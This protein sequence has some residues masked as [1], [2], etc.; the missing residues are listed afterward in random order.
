MAEI[1]GRSVLVVGASG[2]LGSLIAGELSRQGALLTL[3][4]RDAARVTAI[5]VPGATVT[6]DLRDPSKATALVEAAVAAHGCLDGVVIASGVVA[7]GPI[8]SVDDDVLDDLFLIDV[9]APIR[10]TQAAL[11]HLTQSAQDGR[12]PFIAS[13]SGVVAEQPMAGMA[14]YSAA[15]AALMAYDV[16]AARE[17]RRAGIRMIDVRPPHTETGLA[18]RPIAGT[19]PRLPQGLDPQGAAYRIVTAITAD[20]TDLPSSAFTS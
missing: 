13:I 14:A 15:K 10:I 11:P 20:E 18:T 9:L 2:A 1:Q 19:A 16:A 7:F 4:G 17:L 6:G 8:G 5:G 12:A 3:H